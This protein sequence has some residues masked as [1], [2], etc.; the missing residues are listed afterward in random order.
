MAAAVVVLIAAV[1]KSAAPLWLAH[2]DQ[3]SWPATVAAY[4]LGAA[5]AFAVLPGRATPTPPAH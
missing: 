4:V 3:V 5:L 2:P 1:D